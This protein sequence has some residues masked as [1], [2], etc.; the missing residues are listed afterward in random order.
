MPGA[1]GPLVNASRGAL[2][3]SNP[4]IAVLCEMHTSNKVCWAPRM[5]QV[6]LYWLLISADIVQIFLMGELSCGLVQVTA[7]RSVS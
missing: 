7:L 1:Q 4:W 3:T 5:T 2:C 6:S